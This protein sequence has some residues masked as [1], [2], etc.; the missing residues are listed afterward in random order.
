MRRLCHVFS[1]LFAAL[2]R[3]PTAGIAQGYPEQTDRIVPFAAGGAVVRRRL[4]GGKISEKSAN[5]SSSKID[6]GQ[7]YAGAEAREVGAR[8][9][10]TSKQQWSGACT[11]LFR[12]L[13]DTLKDFIPVTEVVR[14][15][16]VLVTYSKLPVT[17]LKEL[18]RSQ[19][20]PFNYGVTGL[21]TASNHRVER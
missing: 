4:V 5:P 2:T 1:I 7:R 21:A 3:N 20:W 14:T 12:T 13:P 15:Q 17:T 6:R 8:R 18:G 16:S 9:I 10:H 11:S 19:A